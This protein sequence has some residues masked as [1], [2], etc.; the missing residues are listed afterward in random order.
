MGRR[1]HHVIIGA[2]AAGLAA[3]ETLR[4][5]GYGGKLTLVGSEALAPYDRPPFSKQVL[6]GKWD[7][8][9][10]LLRGADFYRD[11]GIDLQLGTKA[12]ALDVAGRRLLLDGGRAIDFDGAIIAAGVEPRRLPVGEGLAGLYLLR[13]AEDC[14]RLQA[15]LTGP[16]RVMVVGAGFLGT[17]IAAVLAEAGQD[18]TLVDPLPTPLFRQVG[19]VVGRIVANL[20]RAHGVEVVAGAGISDVEGRGGHVTAALLSNGQRIATDLLIIA[21]GAAPATRW[22]QSSSLDLADGVVCDACLAAAPGVYAAGDI[23]SWPNGRYGGR[24]MRLEHRVNATE[25]GTAAARNL[26]GAAVPFAPIPYFWSDQY[27]AKIQAHG[28]IEG[29]DEAELIEGSIEE[30]RFVMAYRSQ[31]RTQGLLSWNLPR[32]LLRHRAALLAGTPEFA[33]A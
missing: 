10:C 18:V 7:A 3:A 28:L 27:E 23:A 16:R 14:S 13:T 32:S 25:Q 31:G 5:E 15:A 4:L 26:L 2:G 29:A 12:V 17:E 24:R 30:R 9:Q 11:N 20:H 19:P 22:L 33:D 21:V 1:N 8:A 6:A